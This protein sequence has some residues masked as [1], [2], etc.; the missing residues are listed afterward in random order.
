MTTEDQ[1][2][3]TASTKRP[4]AAGDKP[5]IATQSVSPPPAVKVQYQPVSSE[6]LTAFHSQQT[7]AL[8]RPLLLSQLLRHPLPLFLPLPPSPSA[9][10]NRT[11]W[12][13][14]VVHPQTPWTYLNPL[15]LP[16]LH[17]L[18]LAPR[19]LVLPLPF[20]RTVA[21][22]PPRRV[23]PHLFRHPPLPRVPRRALVPQLPAGSKGRLFL[24]RKQRRAPLV[25]S[26]Q[27]RRLLWPRDKC[28]VLQPFNCPKRARCQTKGNPLT[29]RGR[30]ALGIF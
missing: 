28:L 27:P 4:K 15:V 7:D 25:A 24:P 5:E 12:A 20:A 21:F 30:G 8:V 17:E 16:L 3:A 23:L 22:Q 13:L 18:K 11:A 26:P 19:H 10:R 1:E 2:K 6:P 14:P 9:L 29:G